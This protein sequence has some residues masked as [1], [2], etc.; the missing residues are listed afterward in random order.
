M[1]TSYIVSSY[2]LNDVDDNSLCL[3]LISMKCHQAQLQER[4][5]SVASTYQVQMISHTC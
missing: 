5:Q 4:V 2:H 3:S 1:F